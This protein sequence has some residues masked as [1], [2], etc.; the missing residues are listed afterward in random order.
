MLYV[1]A[2]LPVW[3]PTEK[4]YWGPTRLQFSH[5]SFWLSIFLVITLI[6]NIQNI[7]NLI[8]RKEY[9]INGI[10]LLDLNIV[11]FDKKQQHVLWQE[12]NRKLLI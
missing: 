10:V 5:P 3:N 2:R 9:N 7:S 11:L 1:L 4:N 8:G 6:A 12:K